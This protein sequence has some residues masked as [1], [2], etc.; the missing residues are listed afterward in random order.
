MYITEAIRRTEMLIESGNAVMW[1][2]DPGMGKSHCALTLFRKLREAGA[3]LPKPETWGLGV[4]FAA[5]QTP[6][7]LI[8]YQ[9]KGE[10]TFQTID[11]DSGETTSKTVSI[12]DP[13]MPL[14][15]VSTEGK[16]AFMYDK[17]FLIIEEYGQG[18]GDV[19]RAVAEIFLNGGTAPW[20]LPPG[21]VRLGLT[22]TSTKDGVTKDFDFCIARRAV[23][24]ITQDVD[25]WLAYADKE[26]VHQG[27]KWLTMPVMRA[28]AKANPQVLYEDKPEKQGPWANP[29]SVC[30]ADRYLQVSFARKGKTECDEYDTDI[31]AGIVGMPATTSIVSHMQFLTQL[32]QYDEVVADPDN[33][34][35]PGKADL[36]MLMAYQLASVTK[37]TDLAAVIKYMN[38][39]PKD[40]GVTFVTSLLRRDYKSMIN[41]PAMS[42]WISKNASMMAVIS[43][44]ASS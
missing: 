19:K 22:N 40:L 17:F 4:I 3:A 38:R 18:E 15:Y 35:V 1:Q 30:A 16:P 34:P 7:D 20:Y 8:G 25:G 6:P 13:S 36:Q 21:S 27:K 28:W 44:L 5:T 11:V 41:E 23:I 26:Y 32:P 43:S 29:R 9:F 10:R 31:L 33:C 14:W 42:G 12:T 24:N 37:Q 39:L 2:S